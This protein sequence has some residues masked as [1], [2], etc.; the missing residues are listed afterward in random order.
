M[1]TITITITIIIIVVIVVVAIVVVVVV[2][3]VVVAAVAVAIVGATFFGAMIQD[4]GAGQGSAGRDLG[5]LSRAACASAAM[6]QN[7]ATAKPQTK[8]LDFRGLGSSRIPPECGPGSAAQWRHLPPKQT[9]QTRL[10]DAFRCD[11]VLKT[12][13]PSCQLVLHGSQS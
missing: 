5:C 3:V 10:C 12:S 6:K 4:A 1:I 7:L 9:T 8:K 2:V 11:R 13:P